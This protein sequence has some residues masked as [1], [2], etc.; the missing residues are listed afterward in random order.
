[1][2]DEAGAQG[3]GEEPVT[4]PP[5]E[6]TQAVDDRRLLRSQ[7]LAVK[8]L[9]SVQRPREQIADAEALLDLA[10]SLVTSV[11][12]QS[13][14]GITPS[15]FVAGLLKKFGKRW[16]ANDEVASLNWVDVGIATSHVFMAAPGCGTMVGPMS[17][18]VKPRR[19]RVPRKRTA[20]PHGRACPEQLADPSERAKSD[21]D[22]NMAAIFD[23]L[24]RKKNARL[25]HLVLNRGSFAQTVENIFAL[26][27]LV[28]DGRV[29][30]NLNDEGHHIVYPRNAPAASAIASGK[31]SY[32]HF[33]FRFDFKDW[34]LMKGIVAEG[35]ELMSHRSCQGAPG[36]GVN[37]YPA[38]EEQMRHKSSQGAPGAGGTNH[39]VPEELMPHRSSESTPGTGG[40]NHHEPEEL[41]PHRSSQ[42]SPGTGGNNHPE[43]EEL[44][45]HWS[46]QPAPDTGGNNHPEPEVSP[47]AQGTPM[48]KLCR[49]RGLVLQDETVATGTQEVME[50]KKMVATGEQEVMEDKKMVATGAQEVMGDKKMVMDRLEINLTY[51]RRRLFPDH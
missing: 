27:F 6:G 7:Y 47:S 17:T 10:A 23:L 3:R 44:M 28:K 26:S 5:A 20:R 11:R 46:S 13:V 34:K 35:E 42:P 4:P 50:D 12:S 18:E 31:V 19:V 21:T 1:M 2:A 14:L 33:V 43:P 29:E 25:E 15:D 16:G 39:P 45:P 32:N 41:M 24:R 40:N 30:I 36:T 49:N 8:S 48:R 9:I 37:N 38:P 51:K 22:K